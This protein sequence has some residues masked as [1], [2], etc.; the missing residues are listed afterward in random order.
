MN[1]GSTNTVGFAL[2]TRL[3]SGVLCF[4]YPVVLQDPLLWLPGCAPGFFA[5]VTELCSGI[6]CFGYPVV[7]WDSLL[8]LPNCAPGLF[9]LFTWLCS[10]ILCLLLC[11]ALERLIAWNTVFNVRRNDL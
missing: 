9:A 4:V 10:G 1:D 11:S 2:F 3:C 8:C 5:L 6:L 7:L